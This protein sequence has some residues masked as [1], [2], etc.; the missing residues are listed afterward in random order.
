MFDF[1]GHIATDVLRQ[2]KINYITLI[3]V[4]NEMQREKLMRD[5][6]WSAE[7]GTSIQKNEPKHRRISQISGVMVFDKGSALLFLYL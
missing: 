7:C 1:N 3:L 6:P 4:K 5:E 2:R